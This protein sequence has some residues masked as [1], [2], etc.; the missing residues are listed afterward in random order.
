M[1]R[2]FC[3]P[4]TKRTAERVGLQSLHQHTAPVL[5]AAGVQLLYGE[6]SEQ[7]AQHLQFT[8]EMAERAADAIRDSLPAMK[9]VTR[10]VGSRAKVDR[11]ASNRRVSMPDGS[12]AVRL[13]S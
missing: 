5:D 11:V 2:N 8:K 1:G 3:L 4:R 9:A 13:S 6:G 12:I 10:I 7:L